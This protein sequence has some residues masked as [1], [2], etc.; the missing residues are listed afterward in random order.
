MDVFTET[1]NALMSWLTAMATR[2][3]AMQAVMLLL[4][5]GIAWL[6][7]RKWY[8]FVE[9]YLGAQERR[10]LRRATLRGTNRVLF[11]LSMLLVVLAA[12]WILARLGIDTALLNVAVPLLLSF[13]AV[14]FIVYVLRRGFTPSP[15]LRAWEGAVAVSAWLIVALHLLGWLPDLLKALES[16]GITMG[17]ARFS[18]LSLIKLLFAVAF[19][20]IAAGML[21]NMIERRVRRSTSISASMRV[22]LTKFSKFFLYTLAVLFALNSVGIDLTTLTVFSGALGVGLGFGLQRIAS[23][24]ISG[25]ILLFDRSIKPGDVITIGNRFGWVE[26]LH[27]R[28][29]VVRDREGVETL[30]P[31]ENLITS[32][33]TNWS[34]SDPRVRVRV[35]VQIS[36]QSDPETAMALMI[37]AGKSSVR[38][39]ADPEPVVRMLGFGDS[40]INLELRV[41]IV[42]P[43][44]GI[45]GLRSEIYLTMWRLFRERGIEIPYPQRDLRIVSMPPAQD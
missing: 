23:N 45:G 4:A 36:Y 16:V 32:E 10:G 30:I 25:F 9:R 8:A 27:A 42:D 17:D 38:V 12:R 37:E 3:G 43:Q 19:F 31:N 40:G 2:A 39:L 5:A 35:P 44:G 7:H 6:A 14:R 24:F 20:I 28:Y 21:S 18:I 41:W 1:G 33:V 26:A 34:Y 29:I 15:L 22:G 13:A 11:P